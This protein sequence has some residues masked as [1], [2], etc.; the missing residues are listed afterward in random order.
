MLEKRKKPILSQKQIFEQK[1]CEGV[2]RKN[3][4]IKKS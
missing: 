4:G 2:K 3:V 1:K